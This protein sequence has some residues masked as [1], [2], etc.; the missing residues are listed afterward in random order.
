LLDEDLVDVVSSLPVNLKIRGKTRKYAF[1]KSMENR[2]PHDVIW[3]KKT[4]FGAPIQ[5]WLRG[6]LKPLVQELLSEEHLRRQG[7]F[8]P[9]FVQNLLR[10]EANKHDYFANHIWELLTFQLWHKVFIDEPP[11]VFNSSKN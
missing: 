4:G 10:A 11:Y 2:L 3:R 6:E 1:K 8:N 9:K 7:I 5:A